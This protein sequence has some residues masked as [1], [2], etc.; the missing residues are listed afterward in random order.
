MLT[1]LR[2]PG[3]EDIEKV[4]LDF[5]KLSHAANM[6][7]QDR[8]SR[9][10]SDPTPLKSLSKWL[11]LPRVPLGWSRPCSRTRSGSSVCVGGL[12]TKEADLLHPGGSSHQ[13]SLSSVAGLLHV[14]GTTQ[15]VRFCIF[16][17]FMLKVDLEP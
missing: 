8:P 4:R 16:F 17:I 5:W 2:G 11:P 3:L 1:R 9:S 10:E 14:R 6:L 13:P 7:P 12:A 15:V